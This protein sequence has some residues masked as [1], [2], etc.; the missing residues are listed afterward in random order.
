MIKN[1]YNDTDHDCYQGASR[2]RTSADSLNYQT[3]LHRV[4]YNFLRADRDAG[5]TRNSTPSSRSKMKKPVDK[6][7]RKGPIDAAEALPAAA[8]T[9]ID[10][11]DAFASPFDSPF[12]KLNDGPIPS[13]RDEEAGVLQ[14]AI[15][16]SDVLKTE[17]NVALARNDLVAAEG[18]YLAAIAKLDE[19]ELHEGKA[20]ARDFEVPRARSM[21]QCQLALVLSKGERHAEALKA[22]H[23][24]VREAPAYAKAHHR[25]GAVL[26]DLERKAEAELAFRRSEVLQSPQR[27][28]LFSRAQQGLPPY[29][30]REFADL[31][32]GVDPLSFVAPPPPPPP[33]PPAAAA[34]AAGGD[35]GAAA[36]ELLVAALEAAPQLLQLAEALDGAGDHVHAAACSLRVAAAYFAAAGASGGGGG[37]GASSSGAGAAMAAARRLCMDVGVAAHERRDA[38]LAARAWGLAVPHEPEPPAP[39][40]AAKAA[41]AAAAGVATEAAAEAAEAAAEAP[42]RPFSYLAGVAMASAGMGDVGDVR[43]ARALLSRAERAGHPD[44]A[45]ALAALDVRGGGDGG[46]GGEEGEEAAALAELVAGPVRRPSVLTAA[47]PWYRPAVEDTKPSWPGGGAGPGPGPGLGSPNAAVASGGAHSS[48]KM[49]GPSSPSITAQYDY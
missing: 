41:E 36:A 2:P 38:A 6:E 8:A 10:K 17:G 14:V 21:C 29:S 34:A 24:A 30:T 37:G 32:G 40:A 27:T 9:P 7:K 19:G 20:A 4:H 23:A 16:E 5:G 25:M 28:L 26:L 11:D 18:S 42:P 46:G 49:G 35:G 44:A 12:S 22:T 15:R 45:A 1:D 33:P 47:S 13:L 39:G 43:M 31:M 3:Y 48:P